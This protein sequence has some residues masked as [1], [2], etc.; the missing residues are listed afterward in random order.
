[1]SHYDFLRSAYYNNVGL[2]S[3]E[4]GERC[5]KTPPTLT[6]ARF[7]VCCGNP[8]LHNGFVLESGL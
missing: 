7:N 5:F 2:I 6:L 1:M 4:M 8:E 3:Y